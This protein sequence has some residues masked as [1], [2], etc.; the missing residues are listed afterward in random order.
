MTEDAKAKSR[1]GEGVRLQGVETSRSSQKMIRLYPEG[2]LN[3]NLV[4]QNFIVKHV[5]KSL[6]LL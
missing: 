5:V 4:V 3:I 6:V 1:E 2:I